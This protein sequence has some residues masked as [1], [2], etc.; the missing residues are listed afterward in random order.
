[1]DYETIIYQKDEDLAWIKFNR[2]KALNAENVQMTKDFTAAFDEA[3]RDPEV[4]VIILKGEGRAFCAGAD[5]KEASVA[6]PE[7]E[8]IEHLKRLQDSAT[9]VRNT[10]KPV[11]AAVHGYALGAGCEFAMLCD[12]R[13]AAEGTQFGFPEVGAGSSVT[14][15]GSWF[16]PRLV[17]MGKAKELVFTCDR[18]IAQEAKEIGLVNKVV[19]AVQLDAEAR[20][21][22]KKIAGNYQNCVWIMKHILDYAMES[23]LETTLQ[24][25]LDG[26]NMILLQGSQYKGFAARAE[27]IGK[28][29]S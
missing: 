24:M 16:L 11:I 28:D 25:E 22:A 6:R 26:M 2:P 23:S 13:I 19:P 12:I 29:K 18:I 8:R 20:A 17:G 3:R 4:K 15:G 7:A 5:V 14:N 27:Q 10:G 9:A 21:M 1:M